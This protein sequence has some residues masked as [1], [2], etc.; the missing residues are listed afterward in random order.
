MNT[1]TQRIRTFVGPVALALIAGSATQASAAISGPTTNHH[2]LVGNDVVAP[3]P[4]V[5]IEADSKSKLPV[6]RVAPCPG[7]FGGDFG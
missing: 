5:R 1:H 4:G 3:V 7:C 6:I 2:T